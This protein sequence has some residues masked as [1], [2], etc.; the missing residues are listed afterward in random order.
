MKIQEKDYRQVMD[1]IC[2]DQSEI[3]SFLSRLVRCKT[4]STTGD[5]REAVELIKG[6]FEK[7][8]LPYDVL[9]YCK[10]MPNIISSFDGTNAGRHLMFNGHLDV[11]P[12]G[13]EPGWTVDPWSGKIRDGK[14]WGRGTSDM[15]AG[16]TAMIFAYKYLYRMRDR[17]NGRLSISLVADEETGWG[18]GTGYLFNTIPERMNADCVL[19]GEPSGI[20]AISFASKGFMMLTGKIKTRGAIA[21]YSDDSKNAIEIAADVIRDLK[22]LE[23]MSVELPEEINTLLRDDT[24]LALHR[25]VRGEKEANLL[26]KITVD[27]CTIKGGSLSVVIPSDCCFTVSVVFPQGTDVDLLTKKVNEISDKYDDVLLHIDG[28]DMPDMSDKNGELPSI[29]QAAAESI[30]LKRPVLTPDIAISDCRYW[31]YKGIPAYWFGPG[32]ED[33][34]AANE[35]VLI[36]DLLNTVRIHA[37]TA[38]EYLQKQ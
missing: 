32:G 13:K 8:N 26:K 7:E 17:I 4:P 10:T 3:V 21:G 31:R 15:K 35:N 11:M 30:G 33:C 19:S 14:I 1:W 5:T 9:A 23:N 20:S 24:W 2:E 18:R 12:A 38:L 34:S 36:E 28:V 16:V 37:I 6:Y 27:V 22:Q 29:I 25:T